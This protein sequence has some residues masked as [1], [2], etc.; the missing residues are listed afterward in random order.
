MS[1]PRPLAGPGTAATGRFADRRQD[2]SRQSGTDPRDPSTSLY[3]SLVGS[4]TGLRQ[5]AAAHG[6]RQRFRVRLQP[7][8]HQRR[9]P[10]TESAARVHAVSPDPGFSDRHH[11][12]RTAET[13]APGTTGRAGRPGLPAARCRTAIAAPTSRTDRGGAAR[14][15]P[16]AS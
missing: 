4:L 1:P 16:H 2:L 5:A 7:C 14:Q 15:S 6:L 8:R 13:R 3:T 9:R 11:I 12:P 10:L